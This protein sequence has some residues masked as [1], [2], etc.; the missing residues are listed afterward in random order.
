MNKLSAV[1][2]LPLLG[3]GL[4]ACSQQDAS[5]PAAAAAIDDQTL[6]EMG[7]VIKHISPETQETT[8]L[9]LKALRAAADMGNAE[10]MV[11]MGEMYMARRVPLAAGEDADQLALDWWKKS[12]EHGA[13]RGYHNIGLM[14]YNI[15]VPG[16]DGHGADALA[17]DYDEGFKY[18]KAASD[19]GDTKAHR[20][21]GHSYE[22]GW[23]VQQDYAKAAE[24]Y[25]KSGPVSV[26]LANLMLEGKG[27]EQNVDKAIEMYKA[28]AARESG[29]SADEEAAETLAHLYEDGKYVDADQEKALMY[30]RLAADYGSATAKDRLAELEETL[31]MTGS[32]D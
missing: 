13:T 21:V 3:S 15:P 14:Y 32:V 11:Q 29:G 23:G 20:L 4:A 7:Y 27:I 28:V 10:A 25:G 31:A 16:T 12:W 8:D 30:Y 5:A 9:A 1:F 24:Y 19:L 17:L 26:Y 2:L 6:Y 18:F 22:H